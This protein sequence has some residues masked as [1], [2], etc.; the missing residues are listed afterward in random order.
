MGLR[1]KPPGV[2]TLMQGAWRQG[3]L[4]PGTTVTRRPHGPPPLV[5]G[6]LGAARALPPEDHSCPPRRPLAPLFLA[7]VAS[8]SLLLSSLWGV[9][10][11]HSQVEVVKPGPD[12]HP[13]GFPYPALH[14]C[15]WGPHVP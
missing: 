3:G 13:S 10:A 15:K 8:S 6:S 9:L 7:R 11:A 14:P 1:S 5:G 12:S 4:V 2:S